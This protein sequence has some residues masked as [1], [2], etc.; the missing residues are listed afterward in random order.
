MLSN[1]YL[2]MKVIELRNLDCKAQNDLLHQK[3]I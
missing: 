2:F 3:I 1:Q